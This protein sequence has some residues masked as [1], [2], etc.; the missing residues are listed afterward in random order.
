MA[1]S[2]SQNYLQYSDFQPSQIFK[3]KLLDQLAD[4][5]RSWILPNIYLY[6]Q[7]QRK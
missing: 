1:C 6:V 5:D 2:K 4:I 7:G 3:K